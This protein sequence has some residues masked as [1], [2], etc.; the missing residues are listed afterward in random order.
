MSI[1]TI[2]SVIAYLGL[3]TYI[4]WPLFS[5]GLELNQYATPDNF[6]L[7]DQKDRLVQMLK[8]LTLERELGTISESD[9]QEGYE[10]LSSEL[11]QILQL[12][13]NQPSSSSN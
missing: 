13:E 7:S 11:S 9:Y 12:M 2:V 10:S 4:L 8:D 1:W 6:I 5:R 3:L